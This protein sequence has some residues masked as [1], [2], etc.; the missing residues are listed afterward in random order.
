[1]TAN[2][3]QRALINLGISGAAI[4]AG[5]AL[6]PAAT[7][8]ALAQSQGKATDARTAKGAT[9]KSFVDNFDTL[10]KRRW[11]I[12]DGWNNGK[13]Q[14]CTWSRK[15]VSQADGKLTLQFEKRQF[16]DRDFVCGEIQ[17][18]KR[19]GY[20]TYEVRMKAAAGSGLNTG[21]FTYIGATDR[22]PHD[23]ID[24]EVLGKNT[25]QVQVNQYIGGKGGNEKLVPV[26]GGADSG[27]N[28]YA[29]VWEP[30]RL[31]YYL[32]GKLVQE[33]TDPSKIPSHAQGIFFSLW[34]TDKLKD[35]MGTFAYT[36]PTSME[37]DRVAFT[38][39]GDGCQF[40]ESIVCTLN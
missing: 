18:K 39:A 31:R 12:S 7:P 20:G 34:G 16:K 3:I 21:F 40:P 32:N 36:Q 28:D 33:V 14:N 22:Q 4:A 11:F 10:D 13:H 29:Y 1:M 24:F 17:T 6:L 19:F 23:E 15:E 5:A 25:G 37:I 27:F 9:G 2:L 8:P 26:A 30:N 35:W 38:A